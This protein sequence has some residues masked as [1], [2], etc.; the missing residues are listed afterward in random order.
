MADVDAM[1]SAVGV[2][3]VVVESAGHVERMSA[4]SVEQLR[5]VLEAYQ[6]RLV[7]W[8]SETQLRY[9]IL[10]K[11][12]GPRAGASLGHIHSQLIALPFVPTAV[13][14]ELARAAEHRAKTS[15]CAYCDLIE[16]ERSGGV[17][18]VWEREG[19]IAFCPVASWQPREVWLM[20]T[21]HEPSFERT[22]CETL[23]RLASVLLEL[24]ARLE[25]F[26]ASTQYN[27]LLRTAPWTGEFDEAFHWRIELLPRENSFAGCEVATAIHINPLSPEHAAKQLRG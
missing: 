14:T 10:F 20:P 15:R 1:S 27:M 2:H 6:E 5:H 11:N 23:N 21:T 22:A 3:E 13:M 25:S 24:F 16:K 18:V 17:R 9:A 7:H 19:F 8:R 26:P 4:L 12:Q